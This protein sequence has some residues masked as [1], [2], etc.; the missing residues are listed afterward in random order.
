MKVN[1]NYTWFICKECQAVPKIL[2][3]QKFE[4]PEDFTK[5]FECDCIVE[6]PKPKRKKAVKDAT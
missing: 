5:L 4:T 3:G 6:K 2:P 1:A